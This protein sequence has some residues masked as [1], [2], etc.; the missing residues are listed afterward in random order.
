MCLVERNVLG[1]GHGFI[2]VNTGVLIC[3]VWNVAGWGH[4]L[5]SVNTGVLIC[6]VWV[7]MCQGGVMAYLL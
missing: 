3:A 1:W 2:S 7:G 5:F 4:G 6:A